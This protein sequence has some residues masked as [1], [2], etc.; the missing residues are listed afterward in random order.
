MVLRSH[1]QADAPGRPGGGGRGDVRFEIDCGWIVRAGAHP[2][3]ELRRYGNRIVAIRTNDTTPIG[4]VADDGWTA[5]GD[6]IIDWPAL[7]PLFRQTQAEHIVAEHDNPAD[8][9]AFAQRSF[10]YMRAQGL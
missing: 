8:W 4:T 7:I 6:G 5:T 3:A 2:A 10:K 1:R 9:Q